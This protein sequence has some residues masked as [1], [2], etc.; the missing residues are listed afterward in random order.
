LLEKNTQI[1]AEV[2]RFF[3][4]ARDNQESVVLKVCQGADP[5]FANNEALGEL[6]LEGLRPGPRG[7]VRIEVGFLI[8]ADGLLQVTAKDQDTG[9]VTEAVLSLFGLGDSEPSE[10]LDADMIELVD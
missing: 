9:A 7:Q 6:R 1:P 2:S 3:S 5:R 10:V 8:D 4:T